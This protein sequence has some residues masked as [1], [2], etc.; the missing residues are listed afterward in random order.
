VLAT[1]SLV[2]T[3]QL[4]VV[5]VVMVLLFL[6]ELQTC[7]SVTPFIG[8]LQYPAIRKHPPLLM[9]IPVQYR[10][11]YYVVR[12]L[13]PLLRA[14]GCVNSCS[15]QTDDSACYVWRHVTRV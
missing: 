15:V 6:L 8:T 4:E 11:W 1:E 12:V 10:Y 2:L 9:M 14:S 5:M 3:N 13:L 7:G